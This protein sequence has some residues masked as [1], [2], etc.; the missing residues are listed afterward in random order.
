MRLSVRLLHG[1]PTLESDPTRSQEEVE[2]RFVPGSL[3][4]VKVKQIAPFGAFVDLGADDVYGLISITDLKDEGGPVQPED[5]PPVGSE[6]DAVVLGV[7]GPDWRDVRL[8]IRP[9]LLQGAV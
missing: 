5:W 6:V 1:T 9:S 7:T 3:L 8:S 2:R 4:W